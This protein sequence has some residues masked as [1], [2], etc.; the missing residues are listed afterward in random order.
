MT[1]SFTYESYEDQTRQHTDNKI[2]VI[3]EP[4]LKYFLAGKKTVQ[5]RDTVYKIQNWEKA[6]LWYCI[7]TLRE[8]F[9]KL[10]ALKKASDGEEGSL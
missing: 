10:A 1:R 9:K 8:H 5:V 3:V 4:Q 2:K 6:V 7:C